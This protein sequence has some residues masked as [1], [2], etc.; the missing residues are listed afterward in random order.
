MGDKEFC[1]ELCEEILKMIQDDESDY[2]IYAL[3]E[4]TDRMLRDIGEKKFAKEIYKKGIEK[5][6]FN[7]ELDEFNDGRIQV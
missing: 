1:S 3:S 2:D 5:A 4:A 6:K 7:D